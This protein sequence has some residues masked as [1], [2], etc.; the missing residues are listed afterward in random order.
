MPIK[1]FI[2]NLAHKHEINIA[3][4]RVFTFT[5]IYHLHLYKYSLAVSILDKSFIYTFISRIL[6][7]NHTRSRNGAQCEISISDTA[8]KIAHISVSLASKDVEMNTRRLG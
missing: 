4:D 2:A 6:H 1:N 7:G 5:F 3:Y 8:Y